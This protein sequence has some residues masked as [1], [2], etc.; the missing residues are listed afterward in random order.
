MAPLLTGCA[1]VLAIVI[2]FAVLFHLNRKNLNKL[3]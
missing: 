1:L 3:D 2:F